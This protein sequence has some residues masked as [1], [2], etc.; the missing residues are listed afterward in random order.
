MLRLEI[1]AVPAVAGSAGEEERCSITME[2][3]IGAVGSIREMVT[4][5]VDGHAVIPLLGSS[6]FVEHARADINQVASVRPGWA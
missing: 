1:S 4:R 6:A 5:P 3:R 2:L